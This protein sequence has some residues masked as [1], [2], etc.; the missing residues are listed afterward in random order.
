MASLPHGEVRRGPS[1]IMSV[2]CGTDKKYV[3]IGQKVRGE[4]TES[5][6]PT[7]SYKNENTTRGKRI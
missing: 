1:V 4:Q 3:T 2:H 5:S 7:Y 6:S